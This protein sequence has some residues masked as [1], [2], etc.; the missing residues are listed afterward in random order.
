MAL[1]AATAFVATPLVIPHANQHEAILATLGLL[2][3]IAALEELRLRLATAAICLQAALWVGPLLTEQASAWLLFGTMLASL[4]GLMA[5]S[6]RE[7]RRYFRHVLV[8]PG[9]D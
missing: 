5:L 6:L 3:A 7:R 9:T 8:R 2:I 1:G 4:I